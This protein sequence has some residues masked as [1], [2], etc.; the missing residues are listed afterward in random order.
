M[1]RHVH[2]N[3][4]RCKLAVVEPRHGRDR[5]QHIAYQVHEPAGLVLGVKVGIGIGFKD[6]AVPLRE[7][8]LFD[9]VARVLVET[10]GLT[11]GRMQH[12]GTRKR[13]HP[14][15]FRPRVCIRFQRLRHFVHVNRSPC[16]RHVTR[17]ANE[18][19]KRRQVGQQ[20]HNPVFAFGQAV[21]AGQIGCHG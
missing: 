21:G 14:L 3:H 11:V 4:H 6:Q 5:F 16:R 8:E 1:K 2:R 13:G 20:F 18:N 17:H 7:Y 19:L 12:E 10:E 15:S 9:R